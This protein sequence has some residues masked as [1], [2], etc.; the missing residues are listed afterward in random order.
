MKTLNTL[1][2]ASVLLIFFSNLSA[3]PTDFYRSASS[4]QWHQLASWQSS[5][6][7]I[8]WVAATSVPDIDAAQ[9]TILPGHLIDITEAIV[10][11]NTVVNGTLRLLNNGNSTL[12]KGAISLANTS[13]DELII[14]NG[15]TLQ[16]IITTSS[17]NNYNTLMYGTAGNI[18]V[19]TGGKIVIGDG[20]NAHKAPGYSGFASEGA[21]RVKWHDGAVFEWNTTSVNFNQGVDYFPGTTL[22]EHP[23]FRASANWPGT[24]GSTTD[25][26]INGI[27]EVNA[28]YTFPGSN[29][30]TF[31]DGIRGSGKLSQ[32]TSSGS[33][34]LGNDA[35]LDGAGL[36]IQLLRT[37]K[38]GA[39]TT[40]A[41]GGSIN[42][43]GANLDNGSGNFIINGTL[44]IADNAFSPPGTVTIN[45][46]L[47]TSHTNGLRGSSTVFGS[48]TLIVNEG[49]TIEYY[50]DADQKISTNVNYYNLTLRGGKKIFSSSSNIGLH[51]NGTFTIS[52]PDVLVDASTNNIGLT[53]TNSTNFIMDGGRLVLGT[54]GTQPNMDG[55][56]TINGGVI[57]YKNNNV[58]TQTIRSG[59]IYKNIEVTG[60]NVANSNGHINLGENGVFTI[61]T[62]GRF[63]INDN[64]IKAAA[65]NTGQYVIIEPGGILRT[66]N[67]LGLYSNDDDLTNFSAIHNNIPP[68]QISISPN[69]TIE[70]I[71]SGDQS[72]TCDGIN[73]GHINITGTGHKFF[74][75]VMN[76]FGN[77]NNTANFTLNS[78]QPGFLYLGGNSTQTISGTGN[79]YLHTIEMA[80]PSTVTINCVI[81]QV[82][83]HLTLTNGS[84]LLPA[85]AQI[86][87][88]AN[89][90]VTA[91]SG[92]FDA[93]SQGRIIFHGNSQVN[94]LVHFY[95]EVSI[96]GGVNFG[97][98]SSI[99][100]LL[101]I[102]AG[103]Y[104]DVNAPSYAIQSTLVYNTGGLYNR[105]V[106]W[107]SAIG[108]G[109]PYN[110]RL[111][112]NTTLS[113]AGNAGFSNTVFDA[114]GDLTI[115]EGA[116]VYMD[117]GGNNMQLPLTI[118]GSLLL[119]GNLSCS[120]NVGG[121]VKIN[122][123][124]NRGINGNFYPNDR[125]VFFT[126][127]VES[128]LIA[129]STESFD[130]LFIQKDQSVHALNLQ[131]GINISKQLG[132]G[133]GTL[134]LNNS[135]VTLQSG[136]NATASFNSMDDNASIKYSGSGRFVVERYIPLHYKA[137][138]LL[139]APTKGS[140]VKEAWQEGSTTPNN[141][142]Y[143]NFGTT[144]TGN[145]SSWLAD[146]FD[147]FSAAGPS[148]KYYDP[149]LQDFTGIASTLLPIAN[150]SGYFLFVRGDR[151]VTQYNEPATATTLRTR[152]KLYAPGIEAPQPVSINA[153]IFASVGNP[154]ASAIDFETVLTHS[155]G[156]DHS[157]VIWDP[158]LTTSGFS[159]YGYGAYRTI[160]GNAVAPEG[161]AYISGNIPPI[162][163][164][165]AFFVRSGAAP[166][167]VQFAEDAKVTGS[168]SVNREQQEMTEPNAQLRVNLFA[169]HDSN[170]VLV[171]GLLL[172][173]HNSYSPLLDEWD[174]IKLHNP[175][176]N[177]GIYHPQKTISIERKPLP[178]ATDTVFLQLANLRQQTYDLVLSFTRWNNTQTK[179]FVF[180]KYLQTTRQIP[181]DSSLTVQ[182]SVDNNA[183]SKS[184]DRF[185]VYF[186]TEDVL[187]LSMTNVNA[188][189]K[190]EYIEVILKVEDEQNVQSFTLQRS[191][192]GIH[193]SGMSTKEAIGASTYSWYDHEM[194]GGLRYYRI[195]AVKTGG[196]HEYSR[197]VKLTIPISGHSEIA[198]P[199]ITMD[200]TINLK[201]N[202]GA[203]GVYQLKLYNLAGQLITTKHLAYDGKSSVESISINRRLA[204][205]TYYLQVIAPGGKKE[206]L[207]LVCRE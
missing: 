23:V 114:A 198:Y 144:I 18:V 172:Q 51:T 72:T 68:S 169:H 124:W 52:G 175:S 153:N 119:N 43:Y 196:S 202:S 126:G 152:G 14:Q 98:Q 70:F 192:D 195:D 80:N 20:T 44:D 58:T 45:G 32:I 116:S 170:H 73:F 94:G 34:R 79:F 93:L 105:R 207:Q 104:V 89:A 194:E 204:H 75:G 128:N 63:T 168:R 118:G 25:M 141:D 106:E 133:K 132:M 53:T 40:V 157:Y 112:N 149:T 82:D 86:N 36:T 38:L 30:K 130:Y 187:P 99:Q 165:Q 140:S 96:N 7:N 135:D 186:K 17:G 28:D 60:N 48:G 49:N 206:T 19:Q 129:P 113:P 146:G 166:A 191:K 122:G 160:S 37:F 131:T 148:M 90:G 177:I 138:Q 56:Y 16:Y 193:F 81:N 2:Q 87:L 41:A 117:Y 171:D 184:G 143:P 151:S 161:G 123:D 147:A 39:K 197:I 205:A 189:L 134:K 27:F 69:S 109:H 5:V 42:I 164:G 125:A 78:T 83:N 50:A 103:G 1:V 33:F 57:E 163:S 127:N 9:I 71:R 100:K 77:I 185:Y 173:Y 188:Y 35:V 74:K 176:E 26:I 156:L 55:D 31:R 61:K 121:D 203:R 59:K 167:V 182:F 180:D 84:L 159:Q 92:D 181:T 54:T 201:L 11:N 178:L 88:S 10:I 12:I 154:Y 158:R 97:S 47:K 107:S 150:A 155:S 145:T 142:P 3:A 13:N 200:G 111:S 29:D 62:G 6:D 139:A 21:S 64:S 101:Q 65:G 24:N 15:G 110:V 137:W 67:T 91:G 22:T 8:N 4:G 85:G 199:T 174:A 66:G 120:Q 95:P 190:K 183:A 136:M 76:V 162:Q 179:V 46:T 102:N 108:S 115:D